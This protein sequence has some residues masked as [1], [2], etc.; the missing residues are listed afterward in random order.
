MQKRVCAQRTECVQPL[1]RIK[2]AC[3]T[4]EAVPDKLHVPL[5]VVADVTVK[6]PE[7]STKLPARKRMTTHLVNGN[8]YHVHE[9]PHQ[10]KRERRSCTSTCPLSSRWPS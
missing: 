9:P 2:L 3:I 4:R 8:G 10:S 5:M 6:E 1:L 7:E